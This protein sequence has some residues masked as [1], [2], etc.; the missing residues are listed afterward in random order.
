MH[1][2][3][4][5]SAP[6]LPACPR[7]FISLRI[8]S[9]AWRHERPVQGSTA[10]LHA[11]AMA[12]SNKRGLT[13]CHSAQVVLLPIAAG[14]WLNRAFPAAVQSAAPFAPLVA[15]ACTVAVCASVLACNAAAVS[16]AGPALLGAI[17]ALHMGGFGLGYAVSRAVGIPERQVGS[18]NL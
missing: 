8:T 10:A 5:Q 3:C 6:C 14:A 11:A 17:A 12:S 9:L 4:Q 18:R 7:P 13:P 2:A 1:A 15:V 16:A